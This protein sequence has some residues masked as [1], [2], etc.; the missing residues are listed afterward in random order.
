MCG[1][2][3]LCRSRAAPVRPLQ[4]QCHRL[5]QVACSQQLQA[6]T[7]D[8]DG[9]SPLSLPPSPSLPCTLTCARWRRLKSS[10]RCWFSAYVG[11][12]R[13]LWGAA[14]SSA[15]W[16]TWLHSVCGCYRPLITPALNMQRDHRLALPAHHSI[17][18][19]DGSLPSLH[20]AM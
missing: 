10:A 12:S 14:I 9:A 17:R 1:G 4:H 7:T 18:A 19:L 8:V 5:M 16:Q 20:D 2:M 6:R 11:G 3:Q 13:W 15:W